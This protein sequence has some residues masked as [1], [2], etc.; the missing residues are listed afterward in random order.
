[1]SDET[2]RNA[3]NQRKMSILFNI[4]PVRF[5]PI[6]PYSLG[7]TSAQLNMRRKVEVLKY[8]KQSTQT[9]KLTRKE[10]AAM[11]SRGN[12]KGNQLFCTNDHSIPVS[13]SASDVPGPIT[14][15]VEDKTV[16]LYNFI[17][18]QISA[19]GNPIDSEEWS[20]Y[21]IPSVDVPSG[22]DNITNI[23]TLLIRESIKLP[24]YIYVYNVP[25]VYNLQGIDIPYNTSGIIINVNINN[26]TTKIY[27]GSSET[28]NNTSSTSVEINTFRVLLKPDSAITSGTYNYTCSIFAGYMTIANMFIYTSPGFSYNIGVSYNASETT[29]YTEIDMDTNLNINTDS[30]AILQSTSFSMIANIDYNYYIPNNI[31][32]ENK[33]TP[34]ISSKT[35]NFTGT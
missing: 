14:Y 10:R 24:T 17:S 27:Y 9:N 26:P 15:L 28:T 7:Y 16:P 30:T 22:L 1:M 12:F 29:D 4:P 23:G 25:I 13:T 21:T 20:L 11:I 35:I 18:N 33:T 34:S 6:S 8:A 31:N 5:D 2:A 19:D 3:C 32:C